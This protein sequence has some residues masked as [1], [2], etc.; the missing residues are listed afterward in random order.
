MGQFVIYYAGLGTTGRYLTGI[1]EKNDFC[2][3]LGF[4]LAV[5]CPDEKLDCRSLQ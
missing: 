2:E 3:N 5:A 4:E 1:F